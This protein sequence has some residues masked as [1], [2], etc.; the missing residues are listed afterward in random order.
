MH[1]FRK[2]AF[3]QGVNMSAIKGINTAKLSESDLTYICFDIIFLK[4]YNINYEI[5]I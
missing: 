3:L 1:V 4:A 5:D 2:L